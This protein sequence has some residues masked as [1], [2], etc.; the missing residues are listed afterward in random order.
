[1]YFKYDFANVMIIK[2]IAAFLF[3]L[4]LVSCGDG[5]SYS[6]TKINSHKKCAASCVNK[7]RNSYKFSKRGNE[8]RSFRPT[9]N[10]HMRDVTSSLHHIFSH[11]KLFCE[12]R[13]KN[14]CVDKTELVYKNKI[15]KIK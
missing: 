7:C 1:M 9:N 12:K 10:Q 2:L 3:V 8:A 13:C 11:D 6:A 15:K 5:K 4:T 14:L